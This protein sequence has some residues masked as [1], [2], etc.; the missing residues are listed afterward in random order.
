M[1]SDDVVRKL[2]GVKPGRVHQHAV[3]VQGI[4]YPV[5][6]AFA[7]VTGV[8]LLDFTTNTARSAFKRLGFE[9]IR[10]PGD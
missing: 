1:T 7:R 3:K 5:K 10:V 4:Y 2:R 9:V 6:E 8:D